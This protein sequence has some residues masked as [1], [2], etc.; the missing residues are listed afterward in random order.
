MDEN[1]V[2]STNISQ[3]ISDSTDCNM[4]ENKEALKNIFS[5][6]NLDPLPLYDIKVTKTVKNDIMEIM[7]CVLSVIPK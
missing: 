2:E 5:I 6:V 3:N 1:A 4:Y 7:K